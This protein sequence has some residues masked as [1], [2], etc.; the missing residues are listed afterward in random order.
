LSAALAIAPAFITRGGQPATLSLAVMLLLVI[1]TGL[2]ASI[3]A[4]LAAL[5]SP[6]IPALR[7]E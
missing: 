3:L 4:T 2:L 5:R 7:A 6:L 1:I